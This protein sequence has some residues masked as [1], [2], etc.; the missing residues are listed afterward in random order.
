MSFEILETEYLKVKD[1]SLAFIRF[2]ESN[3]DAIDKLD[4][5]DDEQRK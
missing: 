2:Y 1:D 5:S 3:L 4:D